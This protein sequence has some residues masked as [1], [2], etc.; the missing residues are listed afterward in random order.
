[1]ESTIAIIASLCR[2]LTT[3]INVAGSVISRR[4]ELKERNRTR[5]DS[6]RRKLAHQIIGYY[7]E[8]Q[9]LIN[10]LS[11]LT[12]EAESTIRKKMRKK[13]EEYSENKEQI[14]PSMTA[15]EARK[16]IVN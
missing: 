14:Y 7:Y 5:R 13:S 4:E 3:L 8:E 2:V 12:G 11:L 10:E 15:N 6:T 16:Y 1:M 9:V